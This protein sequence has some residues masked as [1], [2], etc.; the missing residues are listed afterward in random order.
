[1]QVLFVQLSSY[2]PSTYP[3]ATYMSHPLGTIRWTDWTVAATGVHSVLTTIA[4]TARAGA[5]LRSDRLLHLPASSFAQVL[6]RGTGDRLQ[7]LRLLAGQTARRLPSFAQ[8]HHNSNAT[9]G[10][11]DTQQHISA[12]FKHR[13]RIVAACDPMRLVC[14]ATR[15]Q[16]PVK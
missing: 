15:N 2:V 13:Y 9:R 1:M 14:H 4:V 12:V 16:K 6:H 5:E 3:H 8:R 7:H 10:P 11:P